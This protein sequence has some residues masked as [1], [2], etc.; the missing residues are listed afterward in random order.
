MVKEKICGVYCIENIANN[1]KYIG[2]S[3]NIFRRWGDHKTHL[4]HNKHHSYKLQRAWCKYS[5]DKFK[6]YIIEEF[7]GIDK[8]LRKLEQYYLDLFKSYDFRFGYNVNSNSLHPEVK[9][10]EYQDII[11]GKFKVSQEQFDEIIYYLSNTKIS[12][13]NISKITKV[14]YR[15]IYQIYFK[16]NYFNVVKD[17]SFNKREAFGENSCTS[18][19]TEVQ[20]KEIINKLLN[21]E[22]IV[23]VSKKYNINSATIW[24]IYNHKTWNSLTK[25]IIFPKYEK[26]TGKYFKK[27]VQYDLDMNLINTY[28]SAKEA[29]KET[30]V[31]RKMI[32]RVCKGERPQTHGFIWKFA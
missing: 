2:S 27:V 5:N 30:G 20:V 7:F 13:P 19:L 31:G 18:K 12:I 22:Y 32:S 26:S 24:D 16:Q 10:T 25:N 21:K 6:F 29:E 15:T 17:M 23:D 8:D 4:K 11:D 14:Q 9:P 28:H 1:K 3:L